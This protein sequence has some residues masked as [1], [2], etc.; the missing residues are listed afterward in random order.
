MDRYRVSER[1][2]KNDIQ[3][4][5]EFLAENK[6]AD[7]L[8]YDNY[9]LTLSDHQRLAA[10]AEALAALDP[11]TYK[12]SLEE[13]K[14]YIA[15]TLLYSEDYYSMQK[16]ADELLVTRNTIINDCKV[17][18]DW[19]K[20]Y[21]I[22]FIARSKKGIRIAGTEDEILSLLTDVF[23]SQM[24]SVQDEQDFFIRFI[25]EQIDFH[26]TLGEIV[27]PM[28]RFTR[29]HSVIFAKEVFFE[30]GILIFV[31][32]NRRAQR[33]VGESLVEAVDEALQRDVLGDMVASIVTEL[34]MD[35]I[36]A[37]DIVAIERE[38]LKRELQ[39][40]IHS[41]DD[42]DLYGAISHFLFAVG[43]EIDGEIQIQSDD[44]LVKS[45]IAHIKSMENWEESS[46]YVGEDVHASDEFQRVRTVAED[47]YPILE[48]YLSYDLTPHM[49]DSIVIHICAALLRGRQ[50]VF[51]HKVVIS[52][53]GS[54]ATSKYLE[55]QIKSY[56][57]FHIVGTMTTRSVEDEDV[58]VGDVDFI[59][60][61]VPIEKTDLPVIV[62]NPLL[63]ID[64][65]D[66]IQT[67]AN[68]KKLPSHRL[69]GRGEASLLSELYEIYES[70]DE[71][72][73]EYLGA[74]LKKMLEHKAL[75]AKRKAKPST[76]LK[77]LDQKYLRLEAGALGW[78]EAMNLAAE[79][80][81]KDGYF[82][83]N[84]LAEA[85]DNVEEYGNYI[86][87]T[88]G[89]ALA[90]AGKTA[91]VYND[92]L[93]LLVAKDGIAFDEDEQVDLLFFFSQKG[94]TDYLDLFKEIIK[95]G[96]DESNI[97]RLKALDDRDA[98][99]ELIAEILTE[100]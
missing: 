33:Q 93:S 70:G 92:G 35:F 6:L 62:V 1:T 98:A 16:L 28:Q 91:G 54:M 81:I 79:E 2:V 11:Y 59:I 9:V 23:S 100:R 78:K 45:L 40:Q 60:S 88:K 32:L 49:K 96:Q 44:L 37:T 7:V 39:P 63:T 10:L 73:I 57:N 55:A 53:P 72:Q 31:M 75:S 4:M 30:M 21:G 65:I 94:D 56:F 20:T 12:F 66:R 95:F 97:R 87:I 26:Y 84:Y 58:A 76:L 82:D 24:D 68:Q 38:I 13:R 90:H 14:I 19:L 86:I 5:F 77:M 36:T 46:F 80:L 47:K 43:E 15:L 50:N 8:S 69:D 42:F 74:Q 85:I 51:I 61:T 64:D 67:Q 71:E 27:E 41:I 22:K 18:D 83:E 3:E 25:M 99:Y 48:N 17:V 89:I 52:C 34:K 29:S